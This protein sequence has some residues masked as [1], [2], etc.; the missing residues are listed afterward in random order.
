M[1]TEPPPLRVPWTPAASGS[2]RCLGGF[3]QVLDV[4]A[5]TAAAH[6]GAFDELRRGTLQ[7]VVLQ[8]V[9]TPAATRVALA[10]LE[11]HDP[12]FLRSSFPAPFR[13]WFY[14]RNISLAHPQLQ[15][16]FE[17][18]AL[19]NAQLAELNS[20]HGPLLPRLL[21]L[22]SALDQGRP[23]AAAPGPAAGLHYMPTTLRAHENGGFI[24][25]HFDNEMRLRPSYRHLEALLEPAIQSFVLT[26]D[27]G[28][29]G[30]A[31][32]V[33]DLSCAPEAAQL[34]NDDHGAPLPPL[35]QA[36]SV[37][38]RL[39]PGAMVVLD[40]GRLLHRLTPVQGG[41]RRW[42]ACSF[43]ARERGGTI[44]RVWG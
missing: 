10:R 20:G 31:L 29:A 28:E 17:E 8:D 43:M 14:G 30:G 36:A 6:A 32:E 4:D 12:P 39:P 27:P 19:F 16:Y 26:L 34:H 7:A 5:T 40:S 18:A 37:S 25:P 22:L 33:F 2:R 38:F 11:A 35:E 24:P 15:G 3:L 42:T 21:A 1:S 23:F 41:R 44:T 13:S 9:C